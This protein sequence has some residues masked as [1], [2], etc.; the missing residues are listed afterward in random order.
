[1]DLKQKSLLSTYVEK[2]ANGNFAEQDVLGFLLLIQKQADDIK[3]INEV[4]ELA[5]NRV[6]YK[7]IIKDYLL[8]T[9]KKFALMSQSKVSLRIHDVF[10]FKELRNGLNKAL[11]DCDMGEL[12]H[13]RINDF[14]ACLIS[15]LQQIIITDEHD[16][17]IGKLFF[18]ISNKEVIL[19]A[20][21]A[22]ANNLLKKTNVV[23][24]VLTANNRYVNL[25][26]QDQYD[27]PY[28]FLDDVVEIVNR[29]GKL[30]IIIPN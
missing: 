19:M 11:S 28:L 15:I 17:E 25:K 5:I 2:L 4:T 20:E 9:R 14:V 10:S 1:M 18:A 26:K 16:K 30:D 12:P 21:V 13:E 3:W 29:D 7:G 8:E 22:I 6:Q 23:F 24:P 27:T